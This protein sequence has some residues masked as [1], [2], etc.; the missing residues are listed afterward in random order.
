MAASRLS[1]SRGSATQTD[2]SRR[3]DRRCAAAVAVTYFFSSAA[4]RFCRSS[5]TLALS[6]GRRMPQ[7]VMSARAGP[8]EAVGWPIVSQELSMAARR[9]IT[10]KFA[11][12]YARADKAGK[13]EIL[14]ALVR[15]A[16]ARVGCRHTCSSTPSTWTPSKRCGSLMRTRLPSANTAS[17]GRAPDRDASS[18]TRQRDEVACLREGGRTRHERGEPVR[19][20]LHRGRASDGRDRSRFAQ[21]E[22]CLTHLE[23]RRV[24]RRAVPNCRSKGRATP[25]LSKHQTHS[26]GAALWGALSGDPAPGADEVGPDKVVWRGSIARSGRVGHA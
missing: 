13:G 5:A 26:L 16:A 1:G 3:A 19:L 6:I 18:A 24:G 23:G 12:E 25:H 7:M 2:P 4:F 15:T 21:H 20:C 14:D 11:R 8:C 10:K 22:A 17:S 9:E